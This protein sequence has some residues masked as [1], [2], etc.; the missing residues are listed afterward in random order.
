M[1]RKLF[2][3]KTLAQLDEQAA[4][5]NHGLRRHLGLTNLTLLGVGSVI[6]AGIFVLT[7]TAAQMHAGPA[8]VLSFVLSAFGCLLA[9]LCYAEFASMI[10]LAGSAYTYG[11]AT[12]GELVAWIIGWDLILEYLFSTATVAVGWSG[13]MLSFLADFG[14]YL[15][16]SLAQAPFEYDQNGWHTTGSIIN[17]PAVFI[18]V[19]LT[20]LLVVGIKETVKFNN[21]TVIIKVIVVLLFVGFGI[22][23][24]HPDNWSPFIP[25][26]TGVWGHYGWSGVLAG[27]GV[28]FF[29]YIGFD[30]VSTTSQEA[31][32][33]KR[34]LPLSIL[35][36]LL[37]CTIL[38]V[39]VSFVLTGI[40]NYKDLNVAAPIALAI[41]KCGNTLNWLSPIIKIGTLAGLSSVILVTLL[42]QTRIFFAMAH[43]GLL[44]K[45]FGKTHK[46]F[47]TPHWSTL[48]TGFFTALMA[49]LFP[50]G[51]LGELVSIG[52]LLAFM[53]VSI[54]IVILR[55]TE[56]DAPRAFRTPWVP[57]VPILGAIVCFVQMLALPGDTWLRLFV[58]M[59]I[60]FV[61]Y[62]GYG[63]KHSVARKHMQEKSDNER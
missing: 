30:A 42:G 2:I 20:V 23:H 57:F 39:A 63:I 62:F 53:I 8:I 7:G 33:P 14:I 60:G 15:P 34:D 29:A 5:D 54:G 4:N 59:A 13:Y 27:S 22:S 47:K 40:V 44:W 52:T 12:M 51:L 16:S 1:I 36:S 41:D 46:R 58:W 26:N 61:V 45:C 43:D 35:F 55:K 28:I 31:I 50:I 3:K 19:L 38:Y 18:V 25:A 10:P 11:Y 32:N 24:I 6:G 48:I 56:P 37:I 17:F 9:G 21:L 49:G